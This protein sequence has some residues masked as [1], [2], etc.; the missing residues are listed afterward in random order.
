VKIGTNFS[1]KEILDLESAGF[2]L[3]QRAVIS[4]RRFFTTQE[5]LFDLSSL[6]TP[7]SLNEILED[8]VR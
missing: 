2:Q 7:A 8:Q 6:P 4:L 1:K 5:L 3:P